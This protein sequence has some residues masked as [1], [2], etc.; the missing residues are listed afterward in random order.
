VRWTADGTGTHHVEIDDAAR[1]EVGATARLIPRPDTGH[2]LTYD[3]VARLVEEFGSLLPVRVEVA[4]PGGIRPF[5]A[6]ELRGSTCRGKP[7]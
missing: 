7:G 6:E 4:G 3:V 5:G 2:R 1:T